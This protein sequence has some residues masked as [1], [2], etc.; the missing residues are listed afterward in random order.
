[1]YLL[2]GVTNTCTTSVTNLT[3][4]GFIQYKVH[5]AAGHWSIYILGFSLKLTVFSCRNSFLIRST[6]KSVIGYEHSFQKIK[7][8]TVQVHT[9]QPLKHQ[10]R[11]MTLIPK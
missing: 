4:S 1:M 6:L 3:L 11:V 9:C 8:Y 5:V 7:F 10:I 2:C